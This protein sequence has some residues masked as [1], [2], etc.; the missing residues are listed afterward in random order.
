MS[1]LTLHPGVQFWHLN[2]P[3]TCPIPPAGT[4]F[5]LALATDLP[6]AAESVAGDIVLGLAE[7]KLVMAAQVDNHGAPTA[8]PMVVDHATDS[9]CR[10]THLTA[11]RVRAIDA[12]MEFFHPPHWPEFEREQAEGDLTSIFGAATRLPPEVAED[13]LT[14]LFPPSLDAAPAKPNLDAAQTKPSSDASPAKPARGRKGGR[15]R[16]TDPTLH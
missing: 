8:L 13:L 5:T 16:R 9:V 14:N 6:L 3:L 15:G 10:H 11:V 12:F 4:V 1:I 7:G 2:L